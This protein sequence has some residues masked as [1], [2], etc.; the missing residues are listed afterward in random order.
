MNSTVESKQRNRRLS[1]R[2]RPRTSVK[3]ECRKG[4]HGLSADVAST[5]LDIS[6]SGVRLT[7]KAPIDHG[8]EVEMIVSGYGMKSPIK[9]IGVVRWLLKLENG[10]FCA[11][12]E[13]QKRIDYRDWQLIASPN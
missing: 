3:V 13:F 2:R 8:T 4:S 7:L 9:R 11:G 10:Q 12:I 6:D 1:Q 5:L